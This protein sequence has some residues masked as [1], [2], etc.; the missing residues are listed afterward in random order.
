[1]AGLAAFVDRI[2]DVGT[3]GDA[4][5]KMGNAYDTP[6]LL[7]VYRCGPYIHDGRAKTLRDVVSICN[8]DNKHGVTS[9]LKESEIDDLVEFLKSLPFEPPPTK[10]PNT[11]KDYTI[12]SYPRPKVGDGPIVKTQ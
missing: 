10:T 2:R 1:M 3:G 6:T 4:R 9:H 12:L 11:V 7:G 8:K 5:E